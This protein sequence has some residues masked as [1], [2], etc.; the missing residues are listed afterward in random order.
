M[1]GGLASVANRVYV[2][3][4]AIA[5]GLTMDEP[6]T[7]PF[8]AGVENCRQMAFANVRFCRLPWH[9]LGFWYLLTV[10]PVPEQPA[11]ETTRKNTTITI[12]IFKAPVFMRSDLYVWWGNICLF[13]R[14][15]SSYRPAAM[16]MQGKHFS[17]H[18]EKMAQINERKDFLY[19]LALFKQRYTRGTSWTQILLNFG[20]ITANAK[21]FEDF[22]SI[23]L[24]LTLPEVIAISIPVYIIF[25]FVI[26]YYDERSGFWQI[27]N[28][29]SY[30]FMPLSEEMLTHIREIRKKL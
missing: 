12:T 21:L 4:L 22:F 5:Y 7:V 2:R 27:G 24:G 11:V 15:P 19:E 29:L 6:F 14:V 3:T 1:T 9:R 30:R 18:R 26:G 23:H 17:S 10:V 25:F 13:L 20:I 16:T 8:C 28:N